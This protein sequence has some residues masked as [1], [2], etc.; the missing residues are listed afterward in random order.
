MNCEEC[1]NE[2]NDY[3]L[4]SDC[5]TELKLQVQRTPVELAAEDLLNACEQVIDIIT[6]S[7]LKGTIKENFSEQAVLAQLSRVL[8]AFKKVNPNNQSIPKNLLEKQNA[9]NKKN[10]KVL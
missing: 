7:K 4:C 5:V 9:Q 3:A 2:I 6:P 10:N 1:G 8:I